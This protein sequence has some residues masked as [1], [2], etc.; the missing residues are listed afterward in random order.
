MEDNGLVISRFGGR[1]ASSGHGSPDATYADHPPLLYG[2]GF[3]ARAIAGHSAAATTAPAWV[4][5]LAAMALLA[6]LLLDAGLSPPAVAAGL[7][8]GLGSSMFFVY[9]TMLDTF[10]TSVPFGLAALLAAQRAKREKPFVWPVTVALGALAALAGWQALF[11]AGCGVFWVL[12]SH[13]HEAGGWRR[14]LPLGIG[15]VGGFAMVVGWVLWVDDSLDVLL[16]QGGVRASSVSVGTWADYQIGALRSLFNPVV[17]LA[18]PLLFAAAYRNR[19]TRGLVVALLVTVVG[20]TAAFRQGAANHVYWNFWLVLPLA[21]AGAAAAELIQTRLRGRRHDLAYTVLVLVAASCVLIPAFFDHGDSRRVVAEG[22]T[23]PAL[24]QR[25]EQLRGG[26]VTVAMNAIPEDTESWIPYLTG[27]PTVTF[28]TR[29]QLLA[30]ATRHPDL[31]VFTGLPPS[32]PKRA[33]LLQ[34]AFVSN[35]NYVLVPASSFP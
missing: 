5:S 13:R 34:R 21:V 25:A 33:E 30:A 26:P 10:V 14:A 9:G 8:L 2:E 24:I 6:W 16:N 15:V 22:T 20:Y 35:D 28:E 19:H 1:Y 7:A 3:V 17:I 29:Q 11:V 18:C 31:L 23:A 12:A 32:G 4:G 27:I